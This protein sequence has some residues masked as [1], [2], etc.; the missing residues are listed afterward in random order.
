MT[1]TNYPPADHV[2]Q[3][4]FQNYPGDLMTPNAG[5]LH[6]TEGT[7][8][9]TYSGGAV[10]PNLTARPNFAKKR[11]DWHQHLPLNRSARA[12][13][14]K[15]GGV[16]TNT[17]NVIQVELV[18][19]C[20]PTHKTSWNGA[21]A[22][23]DY[24]YWPDAPLW[25]LEDLAD[26]LA[27][28]NKTCGIKLTGPA[29]W[30]PYPS[31]YGASR[32][33]LSN[34]GWTDLHGWC[35]HQH[36][37]ENVHGD[38]GNLDFAKLISIAKAK[39]AGTYGKPSAPSTPAVKKVVL[40]SGATL[41]AVA[42][43]AGVAL[44]SL[45]GANPTVKDPSKVRPGQT[46][47][48]PPGA[49]TVTPPAAKPTP[50]PTPKVPVPALCAKT[51]AVTPL[52]PRATGTEVTRLQMQLKKIG[53]TQKTTGTYDTQTV[54]AVNRVIK[55]YPST[56]GKADGIAGPKTRAKIAALAGCK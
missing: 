4:Y 29:L 19:T 54:N 33:R 3:W 23:Q 39:V 15:P 32:A 51:K 7:S 37:P 49:K 13:V 18:G 12:L 22:G 35:G 28:A 9:P 26:F 11:L 17:L 5:V 50:K 42:V 16:Q 56:L 25:A 24:I 8:W 36:V 34:K 44:S 14:N 27:W 38:P 20:D 30:L 48:L 47:I 31:S 46:I 55:K 40:W 2:T 10:A 53:Y 21:K 41:S 1:T 52:R 43:L 6:T 45:I